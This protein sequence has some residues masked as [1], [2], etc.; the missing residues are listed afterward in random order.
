MD[1]IELGFSYNTEGLHQGKLER[2]QG[3]VREMS[4]NFNWIGPWQPWWN[5]GLRG[6]LQQFMAMIYS[7]CTKWSCGFRSICYTRK[8][9]VMLWHSLCSFQAFG[10]QYIILCHAYIQNG[11][12]CHGGEGSGEADASEQAMRDQVQPEVNTGLVCQLGGQD[13]EETGHAGTGN[14]LY[15]VHARM[16]ISLQKE[17]SKVPSRCIYRSQSSGQIHEMVRYTFKWEF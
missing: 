2:C 8:W 12:V 11:L 1:P 4:G 16:L 6:R 10:K 15:C 5:L 17:S 7:F 3:I 13:R 9:I 14:N